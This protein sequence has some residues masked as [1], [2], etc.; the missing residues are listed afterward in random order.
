MTIPA[1]QQIVWSFYQKHKRT[2]PWRDTIDPYWIVVSEIMLQQT[3]VSRVLI[4]FPEF[5]AAFPSFKALSQAPLDEVLRAWQGMGYNRRAKFLR[6][7]ASIIYLKHGGVLPKDPDVLDSFPGIGPATAR[8]IV[9][10]A[11]NSPEVF[12]ETNIR[13]V[14]IHHFFADATHVDDKDIIPI[15]TQTIDTSHPREWY[16]ALMD[17]GSYLGKITV[18]P[19]RKSK[20]YTKQSAFEG[21]S[22]QVRSEC[23]RAVL[24][25]HALSFSELCEKTGHESA[26]VKRAVQELVKEQM[27]QEKN[28]IFSIMN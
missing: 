19:N 8:S 14:L 15:L 21:S 18:N 24:V 1:L 4:K 28:G 12:I 2:L 11:Y 27:I 20:Q 3:Q 26:W 17:Y 10:F 22:R 16:Y 5:I 9:T 13:R 6:E 7:I 25:D 23:L